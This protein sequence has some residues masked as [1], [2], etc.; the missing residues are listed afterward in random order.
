MGKL[1]IST[2]AAA[3]CALLFALPA[4]AA[5]SAKSAPAKTKATKPTTVR[6]AWPAETLSGKI[7]M[8]KPDEKMIVV[9]AADRVPFDMVVTPKTRIQAGNRIVTLKD[10]AQDQNKPVSVKFV[11]ERRG[12]VAE[13]IQV[14]G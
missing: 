8:V 10:L 12:D 7:M 5:D 9:Q 4:A 6:S 1:A 3:V 11:P 2:L 13:S 14:S